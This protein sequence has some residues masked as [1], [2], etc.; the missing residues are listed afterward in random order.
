M[1]KLLK[2]AFFVLAI[3]LLRNVAHA[4]FVTTGP[5]GI[6][7]RGLGLTGDGVGIGQVEST[8]PGDKTNDSLPGNPP[9]D[10]DT[11]TALYNSDVNPVQSF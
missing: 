2:G 8:R 4:S 6:N 9:P 3:V 1:R 5:N 10:F 11:N 7:S